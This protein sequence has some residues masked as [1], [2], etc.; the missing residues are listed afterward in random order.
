MGLANR[1]SISRAFLA[2]VFFL[3]FFLPEWFDS[4]TLPSMILLW[5]VYLLIEGSDVFDGWFARRKDEITEMGKILDPFADVVSRITYF[6]CL[7]AVNIVAPWVLFII[8]YRELSS[9]YIRQD[10]Y[11][12]NYAL[13][14]NL[15]GKTKAVFYSVSCALGLF[16]L[17]LRRFDVTGQFADIVGVVTQVSFVIAVV[18][19]VASL[20]NYLRVY[21][22]KKT[23][24]ASGP[25]APRQQ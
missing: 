15:L 20:A 17:T 11:K 10:L 5:I 25:S 4:F 16:V 2:P 8:I 3:F 24:V 14:A 23:E 6:V 22:Q 19:S 21:I 18:L 7:A 13:A 9:I 1:V 12:M